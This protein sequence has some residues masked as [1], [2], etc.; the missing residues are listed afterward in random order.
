MSPLTL[1]DWYGFFFQPRQAVGGLRG[2][3]IS[4]MPKSV[5]DLGG[6]MGAARI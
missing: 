4:S 5:A 1:L 2:S 6:Q 3:R